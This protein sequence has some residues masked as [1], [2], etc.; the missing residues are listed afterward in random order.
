[1]S[2]QKNLTPRAKE[3]FAMIERSFKSDLSQK[4]FCE[5][6]SIKY[7]TFHWWRQQYKKHHPDFKRASK[8]SEDFIPVHVSSPVG[9]STI[10]HSCKIEY[11]N[12]VVVYLQD[13]NVRVISELI[14][15]QED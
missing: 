9:P 6:H 5:Q 12:G 3:M 10:T 13:V 8:K 7:S 1:M 15:S 4:A 14:Q 2:Q 11:P